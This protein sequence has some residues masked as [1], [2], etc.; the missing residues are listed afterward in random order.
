MTLSKLMHPRC[1][2][3]LGGTVLVTLGLAGVTGWLSSISQ[4]T[5]FNPPYWINWVHLS[6][7]V[8]VLVVARAGAR[9]VQ[10]VFT[11]GAAALG[12]TLGGVGLL[13]GP[14]A[15]TRYNMPE[16]ADPSEHLAHL[17]VGL[18]ALWG[19]SNR[20]VSFYVASESPWGRQK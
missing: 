6:L 18:L 7:G 1:F 20:N 13:F 16:L 3:L 2:L 5:V 14:Y 17:T 9:R 11:L 19:W 4:A 12:T 15:A 8:L 10:N